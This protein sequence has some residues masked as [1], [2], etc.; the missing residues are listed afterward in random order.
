M[1]KLGLHSN[2]L[3][4]YTTL[5]RNIESHVELECQFVAAQPE[6]S[7]S[8]NVQLPCKEAFRAISKWFTLGQIVT[9]SPEINLFLHFSAKNFCVKF[10]FLKFYHYCSPIK[11]SL[12]VKTKQNLIFLFL[13]PRDMAFKRSKDYGGL[14]Y[15]PINVS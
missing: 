12:L 9:R 8:F 1:F 4:Y 5:S 15:Y 14:Y 13:E 2:T 6:D 7:L 10:F 11:R 3:Q